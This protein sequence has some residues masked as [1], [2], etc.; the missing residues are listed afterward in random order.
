V[1]ASTRDVARTG[2]G[3]DDGIIRITGI[4]GDIDDDIALDGR[5]FALTR[6]NR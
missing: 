5:V 4:D 2:D 1:S 3:G 6:T